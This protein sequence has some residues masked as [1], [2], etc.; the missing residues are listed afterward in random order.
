MLASIQPDSD[1]RTTSP[2]SFPTVIHPLRLR[3]H[4]HCRSPQSMG[5]VYQDKRVF[6]EQWKTKFQVYRNQALLK[7]DKTLPVGYVGLSVMGSAICAWPSSPT[8]SFN[9]ATISW[10][11]RYRWMA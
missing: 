10:C 11:K 8:G 7:L 9:S 2:G 3:V 5:T 6:R 4:W 1:L